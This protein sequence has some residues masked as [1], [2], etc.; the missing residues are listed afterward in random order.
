VQLP[1]QLIVLGDTREQAKLLF[2]SHVSVRHPTGE[3]HRHEVHL[4]SKK[5]DT[6]DYALQGFE[7][8]CLIERKGSIREV[9]QNCLTS[10][11]SRFEKC[12]QRLSS[13]C[14]HPLLLFEGDI[15]SL[16]TPT[17]HV[18]NPGHAIDA[19]L[20]LLAKYRIPFYTFKTRTQDDRRLAG[21]YAL[22]AL[23]AGAFNNGGTGNPRGAVAPSLP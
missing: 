5:L 17:Q 16:L 11:S 9:S 23:I 19:L 3:T 7:K 10:D 14:S 15:K 6:G 18:K 1:R 13:E 21:E 22:R 20:L 4:A 8:A 12:L 2:P